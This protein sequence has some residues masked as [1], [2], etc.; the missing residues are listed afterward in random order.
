MK[1]AAC[2]FILLFAGMTATAPR[3]SAQDGSIEFVARA[4]PSGG[5]EEPVR[6]FPFYLLSKSFESI[7]QEAS[8]GSPEPDMAAFI[9]ALEVSPEMKAWMKKNHSTSLA[10]EDFIR[11]L[12]A[13]DVINVPE[14]YKAYMD[15]NSGDQ[16]VD[17]PKPP[18]VKPSDKAS[19][20]AK[21]QKL[22]A[23]YSETIRHYIEQHPRS[24]DGIDLNLAELDPTPKWAALEAKRLPEIH[25]RALNLAQSKYLVARTETNLQGQGFL[26]GIPPGNYW[27]STLDVA[28]DV[29]DVRA[30]WDVPVTVRAGATQ[31]VA[32]SNVNSV[33][34][35]RVSP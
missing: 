22:S 33:Q 20:P 10:G 30:R 35:S 11:K 26:R 1:R 6:G 4:T 17:F 18:K 14:F 7:S 29:G 12:H 15:R 27:I 19:D 8:V 28:A 23:Q 3:A 25:R 34:A 32:L 13:D 5:L 21:Y 9:D 2:C 16:S 31:Y 24:V